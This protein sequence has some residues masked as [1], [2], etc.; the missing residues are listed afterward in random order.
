MLAIAS[1]HAGYDLKREI[2]GHLKE[3]NV[4]FEDFG[5]CDCTTSVDYPDF[6]LKV[7]EAVASG[8]HDRGIIIC[9]TGIGISI[10]ANKVPGIR[11]AVCTDTYMARMSREHNDA[12]V[13]ALGARVLGVGLAVDIVDAW[14]N[15]SFPGGRH[16][17][18]V[19]KFT[20]IEKKYSKTH[21]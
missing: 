20:E 9:G 16:K 15:A 19:D 7:A 12:N 10:A 3:I 11:A 18:R 21:T 4:P 2:I 13:L 1:D 14:L 17:R 8:T 6:G 5:T